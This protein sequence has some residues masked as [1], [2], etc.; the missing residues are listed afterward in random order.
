MTATA[1]PR[2]LPSRA[3]AQV[4]YLLFGAAVGVVAGV[5]GLALD[6]SLALMIAIAVV[7]EVLILRVWMRRTFPWRF[8]R[9]AARL[10]DPEAAPPPGVLV[11]LSVFGNRLES[12]LEGLLAPDFEYRAGGRRIS[13]RRFIASQRRCGKLLQVERTDVDQAVSEPGSDAIW[14]S[15]SQRFTPKH[16][17]PIEVSWL[18]R[19]TLTPDGDQVR[20]ME[21]VAFTR[22]R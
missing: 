7:V 2:R 12:D 11:D 4:G 17:D 6:V 22:V 19:W 1:S 18:D 21:L 9:I 8:R 16:G 20:L 13:R 10:L 14:V 3:R 5:A 15:A